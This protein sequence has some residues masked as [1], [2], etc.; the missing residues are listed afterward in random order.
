M[1]D[2]TTGD[3]KSRHTPTASIGIDARDVLAG[4]YNDIHLEAGR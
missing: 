2:S 4:R 3:Y 1:S